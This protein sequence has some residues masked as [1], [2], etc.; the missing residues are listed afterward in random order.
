MSSTH[1]A[2]AARG[3]G[4]TADNGRRPMVR[5][6][7]LQ[8]LERGAELIA[9]GWCQRALARDRAGRQ[10]EPWSESAESWS[11][12]GALLT[13]WYESKD[14]SR[15]A[16]EAAY[17]ALALATGGRVEEWNGARWRTQRHVRSAFF[18]AHGH[19]AD[20]ARRH[21]YGHGQVSST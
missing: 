20:A 6:E 11:P 8:L 21:V 2:D 19:L 3:A 17:T 1:S 10:V 13:A 14:P 12:L 15:D 16:F 7:D 5:P 4:E 9:R 18:R